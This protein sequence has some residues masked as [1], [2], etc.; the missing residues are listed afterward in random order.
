[1]NK[2]FEQ[3]NDFIAPL[4]RRILLMTAK[5]VVNLIDDAGGIQMVQVGALADE[6]RDV[7][8]FQDYGLTSHPPKKSEAVVLFLGG[9]RAHGVALR[10]DSSAFRKKD[11]E[12]GEVALYT[13]EGDYAHFRR[14]REFLIRSNK[15]N[16]QGETDALMDL[17]IDVATE[18]KNGFDKLSTDTTNT[19]LGPMQLNG[20]AYYTARKVALETLI[21]KLTAMKADE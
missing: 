19:I 15:F 18:A 21:S 12:E 7:E 11:L 9:D 4:K 1:M 14:D 6:T 10:V 13:D 20:F 2:L 16:V 17:L 8:R 3:M 5:A